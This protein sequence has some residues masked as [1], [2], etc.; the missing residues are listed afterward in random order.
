M[1]D[2]V[3]LSI[4]LKVILFGSKVKLNEGCKTDVLKLYM[5]SLSSPSTRDS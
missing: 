4:G 2:I 3:V 5:I 1:L